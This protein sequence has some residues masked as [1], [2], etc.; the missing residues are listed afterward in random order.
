MWCIFVC[1]PN[2]T[3]IICCTAVLAQACGLK[4]KT[5]FVIIVHLWFIRVVDHFP[6]L[7][8]L[9]GAVSRCCNLWCRLFGPSQPW[10]FCPVC[11]TI[12]SI[13]C[14][15]LRRKIHICRWPFSSRTFKCD[16]TFSMRKPITDPQ[17]LE[18]LRRMLGLAK[19]E[20]QGVARTMLSCQTP[21]VFSE[22]YRR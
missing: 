12:L 13:L 8:V 22:P 17:H 7:F 5:S 1:H 11:V 20:N 6:L 10:Q 14:G 19:L 2:L 4:R 9:V 16:R 21:F 15:T 3:I 18:S